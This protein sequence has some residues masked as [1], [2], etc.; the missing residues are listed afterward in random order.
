MQTPIPA[1]AFLG[2]ISDC[3]NITA[4]VVVSDGRDLRFQCL[5]GEFRLPSQLRRPT[6]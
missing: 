4:A 5:V 1:N 3:P 6:H 2:L